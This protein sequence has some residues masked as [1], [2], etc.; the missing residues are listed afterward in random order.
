MRLAESNPSK[1][2]DECDHP[3]DQW[4]FIYTRADWIDGDEDDIYE[5]LLCGKRIEEY[6]PR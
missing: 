6:V 2:R 5:C 3:R 4:K 1:R